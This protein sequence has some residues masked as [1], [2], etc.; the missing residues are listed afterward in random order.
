MNAA[1]D[2]I[3]RWWRELPHKF[4]SVETDEHIVMPNHIHGILVINARVAATLRGRPVQGRR[5]DAPMDNTG[6]DT[7]QPMLGSVID[8]FKTMTTNE[9]IRGVN[10]HG[11]QPFA[12][13]LWQRNYYEHIIRSENEFG[14][15]RQYI[16]NNPTHWQQDENN[17]GRIE[18][19]HPYVGAP[20]EEARNR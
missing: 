4:P 15:I 14:I 3:E 19:G 1:G 10:Q 17:P 18:Q 8:W 12:G 6:N 9:Y 11:W 20:T 16:C 5:P 7:P 13:K 2:M